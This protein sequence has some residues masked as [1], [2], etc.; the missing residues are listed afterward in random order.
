MNDSFA[1]YLKGLKGLLNVTQVSELLGVH[2]DTVYRWVRTMELPAMNIGKTK[3]LLRFAPEDL[4]VWVCEAP[5]LFRG[6]A[7]AIADWMEKQVIRRG[8]PR[9]LLPPLT[10]VLEMIGYDWLDAARRR[11]SPSISVPR[12][13]HDFMEALNKVS[14]AEQHQLLEDIKSGKYDEQIFPVEEAE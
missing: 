5:S 7:R 3:T 13:M 8:G 14:L 12:L 2:K 10:K 6:P 1:V 11:T 4:A 9:F